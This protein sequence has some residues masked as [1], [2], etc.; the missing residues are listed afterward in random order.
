MDVSPLCSLV[1][2]AFFRVCT[3]YAGYT[4]VFKISSEDESD[5]AI[6]EWQCI[7]V[8]FVRQKISCAWY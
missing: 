8:K 5:G 1:R 6:R 4:F 3:V 7:M 2:L